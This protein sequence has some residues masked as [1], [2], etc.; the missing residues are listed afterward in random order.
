M[1]LFVAVEVPA[2]VGYELEAA[3]DPVRSSRPI[4]RWVDPSRYHLTLL[5]LGSV[6]DDAVPAVAAAVEEGCAG[7]G[8]F[9]IALS[10]RLGTFGRRVLWAGLAPCPELEAVALGLRRAVGRVL[11]VPD[12]NRPF[13]AHLT[14]ARAG[15]EAVRKQAVA[16]VA[17][18][19]LSWPVER[20]VLLRSAEG[21]EVVHAV[22]L[23]A[24]GT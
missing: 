3:L 14:V 7:T 21:Y 24:A 17:L 2:P 8:P 9:T 12:G 18:P 15:R 19:E 4:L 6:D 13:S 10:G 23:D 11:G 16:G 22:A 20:V 1:S 5:F